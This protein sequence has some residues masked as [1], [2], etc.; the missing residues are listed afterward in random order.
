MLNRGHVYSEVVDRKAAGRTVVDWM[1][2]RHRHSTAGEWAA[3]IAAGEVEVNGER[4]GEN[5]V[6][7]AGETLSWHRPPWVEPTVPV[8]WRTVYEDAS[9]LAVDKPSGLPT[10]PGAGFLENTLLSLVRRHHPQ[11]SPMHRLGRETSGLVLFAKTSAARAALQAD[12]RKH[13]VEKRYRALAQGICAEDRLDIDTPIGPVPH[14][15]LGTIHAA[16]TAGKPSR[17]IARVLERRVDS[18]LFEVSIE[19]GRPHQIRIHLASAGYPLVGDPV[20]VAGGLPRTRS[21]G[22]PGDGGYFLHAEW[23][24]FRHPETGEAMTLHA[25]PPLPLR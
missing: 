2:T 15:L 7:A 13:A 22:L 21:P 5:R 4:A 23:L 14:P 24:A 17:S 9:L 18:T 8:Y 10:L 6:L 19:T 20:Y 12:W 11:A 25:A 1:S 3:R 16:S